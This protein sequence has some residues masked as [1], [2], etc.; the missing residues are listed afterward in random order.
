MTSIIICVYFKI[1]SKTVL[2]NFDFESPFLSYY[3]YDYSM[4]HL[5]DLE[6][7]KFRK[8]FPQLVARLFLSG[9]TFLASSANQILQWLKTYNFFKLQRRSQIPKMTF[10]FVW[11]AAKQAKS[12]GFN[13]FQLKVKF[14]QS[15]K[16]Y[17]KNSQTFLTENCRWC[18]E[19][20][21][22]QAW[23]KLSATSSLSVPFINLLKNLKK[24]KINFY[25][26]C[27]LKTACKI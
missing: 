21:N 22:K 25:W 1:I 11:I 24:A 20:K 18:G 16:I 15:R 13:F 4:F 2:K 26:K 3:E 5:C 7:H 8:S 27:Y 17:K 6:N 12:S 23:I 10:T 9:R 14:Y 19:I